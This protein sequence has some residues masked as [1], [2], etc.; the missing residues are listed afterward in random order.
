MPVLEKSHSMP[1]EKSSGNLKAKSYGVSQDSGVPIEHRRWADR[2]A[3]ELGLAKPEVRGV[4]VEEM[5]RLKKSEP[6]AFESFAKSMIDF[7]SKRKN[8]TA[9]M[10]EEALKFLNLKK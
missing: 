5:A 7:C 10:V 6:Q 1:S 9:D 4:M 3:K 2:L 8:N